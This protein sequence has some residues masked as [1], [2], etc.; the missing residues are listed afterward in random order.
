MFD[1]T[2]EDEV[3]PAQR[4]IAIQSL[5]ETVKILDND[6]NWNQLLYKEA[7]NIERKYPSLNKG[8]KASQQLKLVK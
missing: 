2:Q 6:S 4:N 1:E 5:Q 3:L 8:L 7:L